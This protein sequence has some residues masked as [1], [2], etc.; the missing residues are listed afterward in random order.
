MVEAAVYE[1]VQSFNHCGQVTSERWDLNNRS[2]KVD[3]EGKLQVLS[4]Y[5]TG[6]VW[7]DAEKAAA[8]GKQR[9]AVELCQFRDGKVFDKEGKE[10]ALN[11]PLAADCFKDSDLAMAWGADKGDRQ[12]RRLIIQRDTSIDDRAARYLADPGAPLRADDAYLSPS[13]A[14]RFPPYGSEDNIKSPS[15]KVVPT[16]TGQRTQV[17]EWTTTVD[18][19]GRSCLS[20]HETFKNIAN[21]DGKLV[22]VDGSGENP[23]PLDLKRHGITHLR[24][25]EGRFY[26][27]DSGAE[28]TINY[29]IDPAQL[30]GRPFFE[31]RGAG[32]DSNHYFI[33]EGLPPGQAVEQ[34]QLVRSECIRDG[35]GVS[36]KER[37]YS[38]AR[39]IVAAEAATKHYTLSA[40]GSSLAGFEAV[41][42]GETH[43]EHGTLRFVF[44][45]EGKDQIRVYEKKGYEDSTWTFL[46]RDDQVKSFIDCRGCQFNTA[47]TNWVK[48]DQMKVK[49]EIL[50]YDEYNPPALDPSLI[51][52]LDPATRRKKM[53]D[54]SN[55][56]ELSL[57]I[58][59]PFSR[60]TDRA[61][62]TA[63][64]Q[65][66]QIASLSLPASGGR[67]RR[68][69]LG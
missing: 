40:D 19:C 51:P 41:K 62:T 8:S 69:A 52:E 58:G 60:A 29:K 33:T 37:V 27:A 18:R 44:K 65:R 68:A 2:F 14:D 15:D 53:H 16:F 35:S 26:N 1:R 67:I 20:T 42:D 34:K 38:V 5:S 45:P 55:D 63:E 49:G 22:T 61:P 66:A 43:P 56:P 7:E 48:N 24:M 46:H 39:S 3:S 12:G 30:E 59:D 23:Q 10:V 54:S 36:H 31:F 47:T 4:R 13:A 11:K 50:P 6:D 25:H 9:F 32:R 57:P 21:A 64:D 17:R 28:V